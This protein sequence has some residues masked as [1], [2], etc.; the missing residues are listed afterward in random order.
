[1]GKMRPDG[2]SKG[3]PFIKLHR[4][5]TGSAAW[6]SLSCEARA[7]LIDVWEWHNGQN[8]GRISYSHRQAR[9]SLHI[10]SARIK[11]AFT[12]LIVEGFLIMRQK[13]SFDWKAGGGKG[14]ATEWEITAEPC[15]GNPPKHCYRRPIEKTTAPRMKPTA[16]QVTPFPTDRLRK[17]A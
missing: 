5:V 2:R 10:G 6:R 16:P 14:L 9:E 13:A 7:L 15:D 17:R 12:E 11:R 4:G 3:E 1:M 8:N